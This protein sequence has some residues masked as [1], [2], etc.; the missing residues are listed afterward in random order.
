MFL[1]ER[2][3]NQSSVIGGGTSKYFIITRFSKWGFEQKLKEEGADANKII[4][5]NIRFQGAMRNDLAVACW[6]SVGC[7]LKDFFPFALPQ[8]LRFLRLDNMLEKQ[9]GVDKFY[10]L[11]CS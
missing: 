2:Q 8:S 10:L 7:D 9:I 11:F 5:E 6:H 1:E 4:Q 3:P